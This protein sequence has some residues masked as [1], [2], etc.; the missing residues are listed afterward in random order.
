MVITRE[1]DYAVR[2]VLALAGHDQDE[3]VSSR[4]LSEEAGVPYEIARG[5]LARLADAGLLDSHRGRQGGYH[6]G[7][8]SGRI[9][10]GEVLAVAG[11]HLELNICVADPANCASSGQ[12]AMH[13]VWASATELLRSYLSQMTLRQVLDGQ[14]DLGRGSAC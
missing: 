5:I 14:S 4:S 8:D 12:C 2:L 11:E 6:L 1:A 7:R 10:I 9:T 13:P 3:A